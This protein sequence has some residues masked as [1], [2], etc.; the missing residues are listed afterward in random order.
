MNVIVT[1][2]GGCDVHGLIFRFIAQ[3]SVI[4]FQ[5]GENLFSVEMVRPGFSEEVRR[6]QL[7][8]T[9]NWGLKG[10]Q[11]LCNPM[12]LSHRGDLGSQQRGAFSMFNPVSWGQV[13]N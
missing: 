8:R 4:H 7:D 13:F 11:H 3:A 10:L 6:C 1:L 2:Q 9:K 5:K 12:A